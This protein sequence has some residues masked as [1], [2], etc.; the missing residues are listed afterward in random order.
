MI[1]KLAL[2]ATVQAA[3]VEDGPWTGHNH[4]K[5]D[6][7]IGVNNGVPYS[8]NASESRRIT[9]PLPIDGAPEHIPGGWENAPNVQNIK[10]FIPDA[11]AWE[12]MLPKRDDLYDFTSFLRAAAK[13][14][15]F[16]GEGNCP[17]LNGKMSCARELATLFA[18][19]SQET[20]YN[21]PSDSVPIHR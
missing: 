6:S 10:E 16:C 2:L 13:F 12:E 9:A 19:L 15:K 4:Y 14:P 18:H 3:I 11:A 8:N 1:S 17:N 21:S 5:S 7:K 20:G